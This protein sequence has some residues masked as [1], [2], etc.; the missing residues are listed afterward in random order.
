MTLRRPLVLLAAA[1]ACVAVV[2]ACGDDADPPE[3]QAQS[4]RLIL[5]WF[6]NPDHAGIYGA[7]D[8]G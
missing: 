7:I 1:L 4:A 3:P 2:S 5:D 6:P 8:E